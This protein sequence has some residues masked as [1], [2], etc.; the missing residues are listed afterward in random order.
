[1]WDNVEKRF[2]PDI[3]IHTLFTLL[4]STLSIPERCAR[5]LAKC[6]QACVHT[7]VH[8]Y[9]CVYVYIHKHIQIIRYALWHKKRKSCVKITSYLL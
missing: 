1:V 5:I 9:V 3:Y 8:A 4:R 7:Y 6:I 2:E